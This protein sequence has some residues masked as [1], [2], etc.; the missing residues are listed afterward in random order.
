MSLA[1]T[2]EIKST[3]F[4]QGDSTTAEAV[5]STLEQEGEF[6]DFF[7]TFDEVVK[8]LNDQAKQQAQQ[9]FLK[10]EI[11]QKDIHEYLNTIKLALS[12][13]YSKMCSEGSA[14]NFPNMKLL[15]LA[16]LIPPSTSVIERGC[17]IMNLLVFTFA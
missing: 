11:K 12:E 2:T 13:K 10:V 8:D 6:Q 15:R 9:K 4:N 17:S 3:T 1:I 5:I 16:L 7:C 14:Q